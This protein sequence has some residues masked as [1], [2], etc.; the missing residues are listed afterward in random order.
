MGNN[1]STVN[2]AELPDDSH[3]SITSGT[4]SDTEDE[5]DQS[6]DIAVLGVHEMWREFLDRLLIRPTNAEFPW[7]NPAQE[8]TLR[9][10]GRRSRNKQDKEQSS[11]PAHHD[12]AMREL[13]ANMYALI[14][15][16]RQ[17]ERDRPLLMDQHNKFQVHSP[18][19]NAELVRLLSYAWLTFDELAQILLRKA[20]TERARCFE[21]LGRPGVAAALLPENLWA[22]YPGCEPNRVQLAKR[23]RLHDR[24]TQYSQIRRLELQ[25]E[26]AAAI[27]KAGVKELYAAQCAFYMSVL[28][29]RPDFFFVKEPH[30]IEPFVVTVMPKAAWGDR[31]HNLL[32]IRIGPVLAKNHPENEDISRPWKSKEHAMSEEQFGLASGRDDEQRPLIDLTQI[33]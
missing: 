23:S 5:H 16:L 2:P 15:K 21:F 17:W 25:L 1:S 19:M 30:S 10:Q 22:E 31:Q 13:R 26:G 32:N 20:S 8:A 7:L 28:R 3:A 29:I 18:R 14:Q 11:L 24:S 12:R 33:D 9:N 4:M 6:I 27:V